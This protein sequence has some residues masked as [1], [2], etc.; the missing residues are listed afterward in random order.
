MAIATQIMLGITGQDKT[1]DAFASVA[2]RASKAGSALK[3]NLGLITAGLGIAGVAYAAKKAVDEMGTI[4][5]RAQQ[6]GVTAD[7]AQKLAGALDQVGIKGVSLDSL[8]DTFSKMTKETG[9]TGAKGFEDTLASIAAIGDEGGRVEAL[10][11]VFGRSLGPN[12]APLVRQG[13]DA[14]RQ[15]LADVMAAMPAVGDAA[16]NAGDRVSDALKIAANTGKAAWQSALGSIILWV[17]DAFG[18]PFGEAM[19]AALANVKWAV[20]MIGLAFSTLFGNIKKVIAFFV[21]DWRGA[22]QWVWNGVSGFV[23]SVFQAFW[24]IFKSIGAMAVSFG[25][26]IWSAMKGDGFDWS[27]IGDDAE[28]ELGKIGGS[29]KDVLK[30][31]IPT[32]NDK[33]K[34]DVIDW[35]AQFAKRDEMIATAR[36]GVASQALLA[37]GGV[38]EGVA[39]EAVK[40]IKDATKEAAFVEAGTYAALKLIMGNRGGAMSAGS[41]SAQAAASYGAGRPAS[42]AGSSAAAD[43]TAGLMQKLIDVAATIE[44][45]V[46]TL[47]LHAARL[48]AV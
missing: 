2:A 39:D 3:R 48:E 46:S 18:M 25:E 30:A 13:P 22:L 11:K 1:G 38:I 9:A 44:R 35:D 40:A 31:A 26:Q 19:G 20:G 42:G 5:D 28:A 33:L 8:A 24:Q 45:G 36:K 47:T 7:Y 21:E 29:L 34:F 43:R 10:A 4:S 16:A 37:S 41:G 15:G 6:M 27:A 32:G 23:V 17:E 14:L 12:L